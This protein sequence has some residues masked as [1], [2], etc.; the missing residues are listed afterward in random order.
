[1]QQITCR[2]WQI[3]SLYVCISWESFCGDSIFV[4]LMDSPFPW[5]WN[6]NEICNLYVSMYK[7]HIREITFQQNRKISTSHK[8]WLSWLKMIRQYFIVVILLQGFYGFQH[9]QNETHTELPISNRREGEYHTETIYGWVG[10]SFYFILAVFIHFLTR[11]GKE[12]ADC[13]N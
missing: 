9:G 1:M 3:A 7:N 12:I 10:S 13:W 8:N 11:D 6:Y 4:D 5:I 2:N